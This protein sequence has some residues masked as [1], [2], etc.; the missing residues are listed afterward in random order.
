M[1]N[2]NGIFRTY[3]FCQTSENSELIVK[4]SSTHPGKLAKVLIYT[5]DLPKRS[6]DEFSLWVYRHMDKAQIISPSALVNKHRQAAIALAA[7]YSE[8]M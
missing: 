1:G 6:I 3:S 2:L 7:H 8:P 5:I 4:A